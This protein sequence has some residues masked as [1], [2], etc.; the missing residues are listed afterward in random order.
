M[1]SMSEGISLLKNA[2]CVCWYIK[3]IF[4]QNLVTEFRVELI[5]YLQD[6]IKNKKN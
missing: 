5:S 1:M 3:A 2:E 4:I 6:S